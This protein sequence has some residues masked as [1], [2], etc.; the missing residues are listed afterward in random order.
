MASR[1]RRKSRVPHRLST[2]TSE[3]DLTDAAVL[4]VQE[5]L[6]FMEGKAE[7]ALA[8]LAAQQARADKLDR[9]LTQARAHL[10]IKP[11]TDAGTGSSTEHGAVAAAMEAHA[12]AAATAAAEAAA[13]ATAAAHL[14]EKNTELAEQVD[15]LQAH[16]RRLTSE[17]HGVAAA[18][19]AVATAASITALS[20]T[21]GVVDA[22]LAGA[23]QV[24]PVATVCR[25]ASLCSDQG[26]TITGLACWKDCVIMAST[27]H[28]LWGATRAASDA[29]NSGYCKTL[30]ALMGCL[31]FH[32]RG[33]RW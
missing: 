15:S 25:A 28:L 8:D 5:Q 29:N 19:G 10:T 7:A 14:Q 17:Q 12:A 9:Q 22:R 6:S 20:A 16:V 1:S 21:H 26:P 27:I 2:L 24:S 30:A 33:L 18:P 23:P 11:P 3:V 4:C 31:C 13:A 32:T